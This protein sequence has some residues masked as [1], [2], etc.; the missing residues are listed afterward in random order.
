MHAS[1]GLEFAVAAL[2]G[3]GLMPAG[4]G[5]EQEEVGGFIWPRRGTRGGWRDQCGR[6]GDVNWAGLMTHLLDSRRSNEAI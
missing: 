5:D 3:L 2:M 6:Q 4:G 1:K